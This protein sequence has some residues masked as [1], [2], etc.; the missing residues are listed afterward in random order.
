MSIMQQRFHELGRQKAD[1]EAR[2]KPIQDVYDALRRQQ[3]DL[4]AQLKPVI[5]QLKA[6]KAPLFEIDNERAA[7]SRALNGQ[8]G[9][10][11]A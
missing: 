6:A 8:T 3:N 2:I 4:D 5:E 7:L 9:A 1:I 11:P 10:P